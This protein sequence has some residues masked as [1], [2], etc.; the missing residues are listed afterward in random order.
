MPT[1]KLTADAARPQY[2]FLCRDCDEEH[3]Q[4][5][6]NGGWVKKRDGDPAQ[7]DACARKCALTA[8]GLWSAGDEVRFAECDACTFY[9]PCVFKGRHYC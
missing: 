5:L 9:E 2:Y 8:K 4:G 1:W 6:V 7:C 3:A